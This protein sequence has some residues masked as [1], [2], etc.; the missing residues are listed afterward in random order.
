MYYCFM[1][2]RV[3]RQYLDEWLDENYP[4][5]LTKLSVKSGV[6]ANSITK[7]RGGR[8]PKSHDLRVQLCEALKI[9]EDD[10]F[11]PAETVENEAPPAKKQRP[12]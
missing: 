10:L 1:S 11:P 8:V 2:R 4:N 7:I 6:P 12:G 3:E 9:T 5:A